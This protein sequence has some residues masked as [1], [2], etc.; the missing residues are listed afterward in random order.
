MK[1]IPKPLYACTVA[2]TA[3]LLWAL[4]P[5][6]TAH[7]QSNRKL[8]KTDID[9]WMTQLS[10]WGRWGKA[11]QVG[12]VNLITPSKRKAAVQLVRGVFRFAGSR[13]RQGEGR[14]Q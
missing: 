14:G 3:F 8:T 4:C 5:G 7:A 10:N 11:D 2:A 12:T 1:K 9:R 13:R 6:G